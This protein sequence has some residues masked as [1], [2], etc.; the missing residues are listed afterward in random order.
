[1]QGSGRHVMHRNHRIMIPVHT[2]TAITSF[3]ESKGAAPMRHLM[4]RQSY[5]A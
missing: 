4:I 2:D 3:L 5:G 1:M